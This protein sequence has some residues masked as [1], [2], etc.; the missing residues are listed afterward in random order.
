MT[1]NNVIIIG[2][3]RSGTN[4]LRDVLCEFEGVATWP[5]D[6]INYLWRHGNVRHPSDEIPAERATPAVQSYMRK[7]FEWVAQRYNAH[8]VVEKTCAN[9]LRVPFV[10]RAVPD[11]RYVYIYRDG[12]DTTGSA[13]LRW[14]ATLDIPYLLEKVRFVPLTDLPYYGTRYLWSRVYRLFSREKRLAFWGPALD[15]MPEILER[16]SLNEVCALQWLRCVEN[17]EAAFTDMPPDRVIRVRYEDFVRDPE[18]QLKRLLA[19][20]EL[21]VPEEELRRAVAGVSSKSIGKGRASLEE[22]EV[23]RLESLIGEALERYG[24]RG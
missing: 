3:P 11:A 15:G 22:G 9:S 4:M 23:K 19:F 24:Y 10:D 1:P 8:T 12:L 18:A 21:E 13:K 6:E 20:L 2:A 14:Q 7:Q 16:H 5:C 17:A